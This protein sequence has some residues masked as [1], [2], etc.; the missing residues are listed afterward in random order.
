MD[1]ILD[2]SRK[3][4]LT[5]KSLKSAL[6]KKSPKRTWVLE[7]TWTPHTR[8]IVLSCL[9]VVVPMIAFTVSVLWI[10]LARSVNLADCPYPDLCPDLGTINTID[11]SA[12]YVDF[13]AGRLVFVSSTIS[14]TLVAALMTMGGFIAARQLLR[15]SQSPGLH[16]TI[17]TPYTTSVLMRLLNAEMFLL[18]DLCFRSILR[19]F[20][21]GSKTSFD[22]NMSRTTAVTQVCLVLF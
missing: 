1:H 13:Q 3:K 5:T 21:C 19:V 7:N 2:I 14:F 17:P 10:V 8:K 20:R 22:R 18:W 9:L 12:Y 11:Q 16:A 15:L 6:P 4:K